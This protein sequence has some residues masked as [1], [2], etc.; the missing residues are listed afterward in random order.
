MIVAHISDIHLQPEG[1]LAHDVA[2]TAGGLAAAV[3]RLAALDPPADAVLITGDLVDLPDAGAYAQLRRSLAPLA[4]PVYLIPGNR[5]DRECLRAAFADAGYLPE[6][7]AFLHYAVEHLPVRLLAL[8]TVKA[9]AKTGEMCE[10][11]L[12]WLE[13][14]LA[15]APGRPTVILMHHPPFKTGIPF[16]DGQDFAGADAFAGIVGAHDNVERV[17]CGH[18]HRSIQRRFA[19]TL[20]CVAPSTAFHMPLDLRPGVDLSL[21]LEPSA[22]FLH[23]WAPGVGMVTH[24]L[25]L[26][27]HP[28]PYPFR[29]RP[30]Q[31]AETGGAPYRA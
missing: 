25:P 1:E 27:E 12:L 30:A 19:G 8:D 13:D 14:R 4:A 26:V 24:T 10:E 28:G 6:D 21:V 17:L 9:G 22:G 7:G 18:L 20:A 31:G 23:V 5:D 11:R 16:M 29:R 3:E 2:D 15:E